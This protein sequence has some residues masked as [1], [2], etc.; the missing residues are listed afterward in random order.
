MSK[1]NQFQIVDLAKKYKKTPEQILLRYQLDMGHIAL[2]LLQSKTELKSNL[3]I[4][5]FE[6]SK[7]DLTYLEKLDR[8]TKT[9][10]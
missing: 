6:L 5:K 9:F 1:L 8:R 4:F 10:I 2:S 7:S 3:E